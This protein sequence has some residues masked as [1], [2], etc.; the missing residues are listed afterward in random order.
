MVV[1]SLVVVLQAYTQVIID[2]T[3]HWENMQLVVC[4]IYNFLKK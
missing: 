1:L 2:Q 3:V 4:K